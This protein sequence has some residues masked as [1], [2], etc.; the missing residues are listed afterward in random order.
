MSIGGTG[1]SARRDSRF[2]ELEAFEFALCF[3]PFGDDF[4]A[5][6]YRMGIEFFRINSFR[7]LGEEQ[8]AH[9]ENRYL[10]LVGQVEDFSSGV[11]SIG[12]SGR[13]HDET[14]EFTLRSAV[15]LEEVGLFSFGGQA[16]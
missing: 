7:V 14:R 2:G 1:I 5:V 8:V 11:I 12:H 9:D 15:N 10:I 4:T 3:A 16:G 6:D 13:G